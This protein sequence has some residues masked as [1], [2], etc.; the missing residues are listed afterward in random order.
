M[1]E[2]TGIE[3]SHDRMMC[4]SV[5]N[6]CGVRFRMEFTQ[7][8]HSSGVSKCTDMAVQ[9][10]LGTTQYLLCFDAFNSLVE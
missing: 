3:S 10:Y 5:R 6:Y 8:V 4:K 1:L 2:S 9:S 7:G